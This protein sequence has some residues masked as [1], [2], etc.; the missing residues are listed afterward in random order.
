MWNAEIFDGWDIHGNANGGY[1]LAIAGRAMGEAAGRPPATITCHYLRPGR[2]GPVEIDVD[3]VRSGRRF[4]TVRAT[5]TGSDGPIITLLGTFGE[6]QAGGPELSTFLEAV[7]VPPFEDCVAR[8]ETAEL[9]AMMS[10]LDARFHPDDVG[11]QTGA[12]SGSPEMRGWFAFA[13]GSSIDAYGL[14]L[15]ADAFAPPVFNTELPVAWVPTVELTVHVRAVP[16]PGP[17]RGRFRSIVIQDGLL[18]EEGVFVDAAGRVVAQARQLALL[19][20]G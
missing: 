14:L 2:P 12:P 18:D 17:L 20:R 15:A 6:Q 10:K 16:A 1:L 19:P 13:D 7:D 4:A 11:Y 8:P 3:V 5:M 9:P